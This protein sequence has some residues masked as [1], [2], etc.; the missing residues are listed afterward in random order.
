MT[1]SAA[2]KNL[3]AVDPSEWAS[4]GQD[5]TYSD[6]KYRIFVSDK[7]GGFDDIVKVHEALEHTGLIVNSREP[8][9]GDCGIT[10]TEGHTTLGFGD[11]KGGFYDRVAL[12]DNAA[13]LAELGKGFSFEVGF[14][15]RNEREVIEA[16]SQAATF[17]ASNRDQAILKKAAHERELAALAKRDREYEALASKLQASAG[18]NDAADEAFVVSYIKTQLQGLIP[19]GVIEILAPEAAP[20]IEWVYGL[21]TQERKVRIALTGG[22][23][24]KFRDAPFDEKSRFMDTLSNALSEKLP[25][26]RREFANINGVEKGSVL[27]ARIVGSSAKLAAEISGAL[28]ETISSGLTPPTGRYGAAEK[29][30]SRPA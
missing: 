25:L 11:G 19:G 23:L 10:T 27:T 16:L 8:S 9:V 14:G 21:K 3:F 29:P 28:E 1:I 30:S 17:I 6:D 4:Y 5:V 12:S 2:L 24:K 18:R 13:A 26:T 20:A 7:L 15:N 22:E